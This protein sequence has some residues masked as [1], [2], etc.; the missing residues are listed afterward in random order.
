MPTCDDGLR[1]RCT[2]KRHDDNVAYVR[3]LT[4]ATEVTKAQFSSYNRR[5]EVRYIRISALR[6]N[7]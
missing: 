4:A 5:R 6:S 7:F 3:G 2:E 1:I